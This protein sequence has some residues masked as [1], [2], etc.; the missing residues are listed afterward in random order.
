M[1]SDQFARALAAI[2][3]AAALAVWW[4]VW[5]STPFQP[6]IRAV[7]TFGLYR[8]AGRWA[9]QSRRHGRRTRVLAAARAALRARARRRALIAARAAAIGNLFQAGRVYHR[10]PTYDMG[11]LDEVSAWSPPVPVDALDAEAER[12]RRAR[13][14]QLAATALDTDLDDA[15]DRFLDT[16]RVELER[17]PRPEGRRGGGEFMGVDFGTVAVWTESPGADVD[18]EP[19]TAEDLADAELVAR[20]REVARAELAAALLE[21]L[22]AVEE[23]AVEQPRPAG[24]TPVQ[25][26]G[27]DE[28]WSPAAE[29]GADE[30]PATLAH[31]PPS[32]MERDILA[33]FDACVEDAR[34]RPP[35]LVALGVIVDEAMELAQV[36]SAAHRRWRQQVF[37][38]PTGEFR[39]VPQ[40]A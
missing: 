27:A 20:L 37:D 6:A 25:H 4:Y 35:W 19:L 34:T 16:L 18:N 39:L 2:V 17:F 21:P 14:E 3:A 9:W 31:T 36:D 38:I 5:A 33:E 40:P 10:G 7:I 28:E 23:P 13:Y 12:A 15:R 24:S 26:Q 1:S 22:P 8:P 32:L 30:K 11:W 29:V